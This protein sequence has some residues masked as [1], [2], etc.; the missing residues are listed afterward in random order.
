MLNVRTLLKATKNLV[1][2]GELV[3]HNDLLILEELAKAVKEN[4][5]A[6]KSYDDW[7]FNELKKY[8]GDFRPYAEALI[9]LCDACEVQKEEE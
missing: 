8:L 6:K 2:E 9:E 7:R 1:S 5:R 3:N 4:I